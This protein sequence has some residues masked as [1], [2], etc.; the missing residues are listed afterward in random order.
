M[1]VLLVACAAE[2]SLTNLLV[3]KSPNRFQQH[4]VEAVFYLNGLLQTPHPAPFCCV[5][6][7]SSL[8]V[9]DRCGGAPDVQ[10]L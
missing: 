8:L 7:L 10:P 2:Q 6:D 3:T 4:F 5:D 9:C 1:V